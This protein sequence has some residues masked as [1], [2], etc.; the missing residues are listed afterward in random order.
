MVAAGQRDGKGGDAGMGEDR[1]FQKALSAFTHDV[2]SGGA[3]RHLTDLGYTARQIKEQLAFPTPYERVRETMREHLLDKGI[4]LEEEPGCGRVREQAEY[5]LEHDQYGR[6]SFRKVIR[7]DVSEARGIRR[8][9]AAKD[10][11]EICRAGNA[12]GACSAG[13]TGGDGTVRWTER[14]L[15]GEDAAAFAVFLEERCRADGREGAYVSCDLGLLCKRDPAGYEQVL[16]LLEEGQREYVLSVFWVRKR[17]YHRLD[18]R[19]QTIVVRLYRA[20]AYH[21]ACCFLKTGEKVLF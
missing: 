17:V 9:G 21:G 13:S 8:A 3:I 11:G 1:Y 20:D 15:R 10:G 4:L 5:V 16:S 6:T 12:V 18:A 14:D 2:A 19:M 7:E